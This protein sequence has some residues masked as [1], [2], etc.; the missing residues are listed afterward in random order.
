[1]AASQ[2]YKWY[3]SSFRLLLFDYH[4][5]LQ[6]TNNKQKLTESIAKWDSHLASVLASQ[7]RLQN[8]TNV[9]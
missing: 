1:M 4:M 3:T 5:Q 2:T 7:V 8:H 6:N 9:H